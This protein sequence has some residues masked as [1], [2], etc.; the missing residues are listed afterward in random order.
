MAGEGTTKTMEH[1]QDAFHD[2]Y[3]RHYSYI[4]A[5][6]YRRTSHRETA[7]DM[8]QEAFTRGW[9]AFP[10]VYVEGE[11]ANLRGWL[12]TIINNIVN[13]W[14]RHQKLKVFVPFDEE[15]VGIDEDGNDFENKEADR[16]ILR[17]ALSRMPEDE[18][19]RV[20]QWAGD[21]GGR[22]MGQYWGIGLHRANEKAQRARKRF[23]SEARS[24]MEKV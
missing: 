7:Q 13:D 6:A 3:R 21:M 11:G 5:I 1:L 16:E 12:S 8:T 9:K 20:L 22:A 15:Y 17:L 4:F 2:L 10:K 18:Q 23:V 14:L 19:L 24:V